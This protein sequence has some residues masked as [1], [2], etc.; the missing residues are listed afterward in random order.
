MNNWMHLINNI[1]HNGKFEQTGRKG[2]SLLI[3]WLFSPLNCLLNQSG[4]WLAAH[5]S[6][7]YKI[8]EG[9]HYITI[10]LFMINPAFPILLSFAHTPEHPSQ[11]IGCSPPCLPCMK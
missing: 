2:L 5:A 6:F 9:A 4:R 11:E 7:L 10:N 3:S 8:E 1:R